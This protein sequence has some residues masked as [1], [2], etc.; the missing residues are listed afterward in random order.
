M[1]KKEKWI[2]YGSDL[3]PFTLKV[4]A[5]CSFAGLDYRYFPEQGNTLENLRIQFRL[6][7]LNAGLLRLTWPEM[8]ELDEFP[9]VP[10]LFGPNGENL[11]D[12]SAIAV[13]LDRESRE[14]NEVARFYPED[15]PALNFTTW[16]IDE[17]ADEYGLYMVHHFRWKVSA[18]DNNAGIR[19]ARELRSMAGP[20][21]PLV[22]RHF[23]ARQ[24]R[25]LPYLFSVAPEGFHMNGL[26]ARLQPPSRA[27]F[28][29][30][31]E[32]LEDSFARLLEALETILRS[33][34]YI[35][36]DR[37]TAADAGVYG[38]ISMNL[39]DPSAEKFIEEK[40]PTVFAWTH[41]IRKADFT[42]SKLDGR[43]TL[44]GSITP[45]LREICR[46]Y[47]PLM[48]QNYQAYTRQKDL[49]ETLFNEAAFNKD[50]ALYDGEIDRHPFR[51]VVK[52]FQI[53]TWLNIRRKWSELDEDSKQ[54]M[55][56]VLPTDH[57][58]GQ[59]I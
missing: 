4:L 43:L 7:L 39:D 40:A 14:K 57:G 56:S 49:G 38:Q 50:R 25:R 16:L 20:A 36:G 28:P 52:S 5:L 9:L 30:T 41:R 54:R 58:L 31:H 21:R 1:Q 51:S 35:L 47:V 24:A 13:W 44:N 10:Y 12:S 17:Y 11:Y 45:L 29:P 34:P 15:D 59:D 48:K 8:D 42:N 22:A 46:T 26:P 27:G 37:F 3:S 18:H 53:K 19:L 33:Q 2:V 55:E 23:S 6:K 32:L